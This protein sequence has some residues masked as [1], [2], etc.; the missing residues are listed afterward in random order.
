MEENK[1]DGY[2]F[3]TRSIPIGETPY[4]SQ[5]TAFNEFREPQ[6]LGEDTG[7]GSRNIIIILLTFL[8]VLSFLGSNSIA[9]MGEW[10][11]QLI[12]LIKQFIVYILSFFGYT[13]GA[14][15]STSAD[16]VGNT[17]IAG[18]D[19][20]K[21]TVKSAGEVLK[22]VSALDHTIQRSSYVVNE[23]EPVRES[24]PIVRPN[25]KQSWCLVG[26]HMDKRACIQIDEY[27]KCMSNQVYPSQKMCL[28][29]TLSP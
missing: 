25:T 12:D 10:I 3:G 6:P 16:V 19:I 20:A 28:N 22:G 11:G 27:D 5:E 15:L 9:M 29:P 21:D 17:V 18:A 23:P 26:E 4:V 7:V 14:V 8:L 24:S 2:L 13:A 1:D